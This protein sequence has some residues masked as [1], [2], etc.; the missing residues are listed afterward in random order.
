MYKRHP[1]E[2]PVPIPTPTQ[3]KELQ[4]MFGAWDERAL[5]HSDQGHHR[6]ARGTSVKA[7]P[8]IMNRGPEFPPKPLALGHRIWPLPPGLLIETSVTLCGA[9]FWQPFTVEQLAKL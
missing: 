1:N 2:L 5:L 6:L 4:G 7:V 8:F 3:L 9:G